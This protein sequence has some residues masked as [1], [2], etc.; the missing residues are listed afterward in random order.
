MSKLYINEASATSVYEILESEVNIGR[1][2]ANQVQLRDPRASKRHATIKQVQ[3]RLK[4]VD[5]ESKNGTRI[6]GAFQN[7]HWLR[8]GDTIT[9]GKAVIRY[10]ADDEAGAQAPPVP[11]VSPKAAVPPTAAVPPGVPVR[12]AAAVP[13]PPP[14]ARPAA[15]RPVAAAPSP[16]AAVP[17]APARK[18]PVVSARK[19]GPAAARRA[20]RDD[21]YDD[22][23]D[24]ERPRFERKKG[25]DSSVIILI[26]GISAV[27]LALLF[28]LVMKPSMSH[29]K[30]VWLKA[31]ELAAP[32]DR[33][34][35]AAI[36][37]AERNAQPDDSFDYS[38]LEEDIVKWRDL[39]LQVEQQGRSEEARK[40]LDDNITK[41]TRTSGF[42]PKNPK[43][44]AEIAD[45]LREFL[46]K[47]EGTDP[48]LDL[49]SERPGEPWET[50]R[51]ILQRNA[52]GDVDVEAVLR[53]A[54]QK[55]KEL[56]Q[57]GKYGEALMVYDDLKRTQS[58]L[59]QAE[60][61]STVARKAD[62]GR[63]KILADAED[64]FESE[65]RQVDSLVNRGDV[66][67]ARAKLKLIIETYGVP[68]L[69]N[70]AKD[71]LEELE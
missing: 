40:Y 14:T 69:V 29:N 2:A 10:T 27:V 26:G 58:V 21:R 52:P 36:A 22:E 1:G 68:R 24:D 60:V 41:F 71:K 19:A 47:Y 4:L 20:P 66:R 13:P 34:Y 8:Q 33:D 23:Y 51:Y 65:M 32:P 67:T 31:N 7:Q 56:A 44:S 59:L 43:S 63:A 17:R 30:E 54:T 45:L 15:P 37:Y 28:F 12:P 16:A 9:V 50:F 3:G 42:S 35:A 55:A 11:A 6:N 70:Q 38:R 5:L 25:M 62:E 57:A 18:A 46:V 53:T 48:A 39:K 49:M 61:Y 64:A